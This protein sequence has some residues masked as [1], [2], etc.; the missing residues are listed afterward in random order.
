MEVVVWVC[1][2]VFLPVSSIS[3]EHYYGCHPPTHTRILGQPTSLPG[4]LVLP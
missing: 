4:F 3:Q 1:V 2:G